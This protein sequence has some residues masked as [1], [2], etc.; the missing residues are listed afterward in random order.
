MSD[1]PMADIRFSHREAREMMAALRTHR[2]TLWEALRAC[3]KQYM[4]AEVTQGLRAA[5]RA[6]RDAINNVNEAYYAV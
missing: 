2:R 5:I 4:P 1:F 3:E 6:T